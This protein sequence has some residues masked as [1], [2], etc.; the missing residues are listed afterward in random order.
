ML[1]CEARGG[2]CSGLSGSS[3]DWWEV[4]QHARSETNFHEKCRA[5]QLQSTLTIT[6]LGVPMAMR[7]SVT[8]G[9]GREAGQRT[10]A[11]RLTLSCGSCAPIA[12]CPAMGA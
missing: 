3:E 7:G 6:A 8:S 4:S 12:S 9:G 1:R 10:C 2:I 5:H 11:L